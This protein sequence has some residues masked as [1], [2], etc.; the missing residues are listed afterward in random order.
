MRV[1]AVAGV[2]DAITPV[3]AVLAVEAEAHTHRAIWPSS[4]GTTTPAVS[5]R[6][7]QPAALAARQAGLVAIHSLQALAGLRFAPRVGMVAPG[8]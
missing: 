8:A 2:A 6:L 3:S 5:A 1:R 7:A 4:A